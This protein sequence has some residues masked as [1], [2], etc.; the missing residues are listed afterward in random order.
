MIR[1]FIELKVIHTDRQQLHP[2]GRNRIPRDLVFQRLPEFCRTFAVRI[3]ICDARKVRDKRIF[4]MNR[5]VIYCNFEL[6]QIE[7]QR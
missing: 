3:A 5:K 6:E 1:D 4:L 7:N 2:S